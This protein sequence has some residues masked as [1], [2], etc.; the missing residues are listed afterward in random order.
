M[1]GIRKIGPCS[2]TNTLKHY[3]RITTQNKNANAAAYRQ[4]IESY[5]PTDIYQANLARRQLTRLGVKTPVLKDE[6]QVTGNRTAYIYFFQ[7]RS[8]SGDYKNMQ[9]TVAAGLAGRE[10]KGLTDEQRKVRRLEIPVGSV[11]DAL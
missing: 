2:L 8:K 11:A 4:W 10:W 7:S 3:N 9:I 6:R 5:T 1:S